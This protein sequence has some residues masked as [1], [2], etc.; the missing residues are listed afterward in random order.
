MIAQ[1]TDQE[2]DA[3]PSFP[4]SSTPERLNHRHEWGYRAGH[5]ARLLGKPDT[6]NPFV[7]GRFMPM[8]RGWARGWAHADR[9]LRREPAVTEL[10]RLLDNV[11]AYVGNAKVDNTQ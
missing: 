8:R 11:G 4:F 2:V 3:L 9:M 7:D 10:V 1:L 6:T 5:R